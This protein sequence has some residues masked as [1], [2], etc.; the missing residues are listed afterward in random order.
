MQKPTSSLWKDVVQRLKAPGIARVHA[1]PEEIAQLCLQHRHSS[2]DR[3]ADPAAWTKTAAKCLGQFDWKFMEKTP[4]APFFLEWSELD[5]HGHPQSCCE[6]IDPLPLDTGGRNSKAYFFSVCENENGGRVGS[7]KL[8]RVSFGQLE[9][10]FG[11]KFPE[12]MGAKMVEA[13][14]PGNIIQ[15]IDDLVKAVFLRM[16]PGERFGGGQAPNEQESRAINARQQAIK[17]YMPLFMLG[18]AEEVKKHLKNK[19]TL[20]VLRYLA[21]RPL[22]LRY[23]VTEDE[24]VKWLVQPNAPNDPIRRVQND[25]SSNPDDIRRVLLDFNRLTDSTIPCFHFQKHI[26]IAQAYVKYVVAEFGLPAGN[27]L[28]Q[29]PDQT[30]D[31]FLDFLVSPRFILTGWPA[32]AYSGQ[33]PA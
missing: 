27:V 32:A 31:E 21:A 20:P 3:D 19:A 15:L 26:G 23:L 18:I 17:R 22:N 8:L 30:F 2:V 6:R 5:A 24:V 12:E 33:Y 11:R 25:E 7:P 29:C 1:S 14:K 4:L 13:A 28:W 10:G 16:G 9:P